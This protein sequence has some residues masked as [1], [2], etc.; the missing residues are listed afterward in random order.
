MNNK[1]TV[2]VFHLLSTHLELSISVWPRSPSLGQFLKKK[3]NVYVCH[4]SVLWS[5]DAIHLLGLCV[6]FSQVMSYTYSVALRS[7]DTFNCVYLI[8]FRPNMSH[9]A[10]T[11]GPSLSIYFVTLRPPDLLLLLLG[12][13]KA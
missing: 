3:K 10:M 2:S 12:V 13:R 4:S 1:L 8:T 9:Y 5:Y 11:A 6:S 7:S